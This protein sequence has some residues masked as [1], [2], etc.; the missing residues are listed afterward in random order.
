MANLI[1]FVILLAFFWGRSLR[2]KNLRLHIAVM[3]TVIASDV[4]LVLALIIRRDALSK[5]SLGM[6]WT[7]KI[8]VPIAV[9]TILLYFVTAWTGVQLLRGKP[10][11]ARMRRLDRI[12]VPARVLT[13]VTSLMVQF[14]RP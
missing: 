10:L 2:F 6:P 1:S 12:V 14:L 13:F 3:S 8:H 11:H 4:L 5:V 7:L 9:A